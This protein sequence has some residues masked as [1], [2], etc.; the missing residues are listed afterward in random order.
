MSVPT[1]LTDGR[2][3]AER[4]ELITESQH[5]RGSG[6]ACRVAG[7]RVERDQ[8][9]VRRQGAGQFGELTRIAEA[10]RCRRRSAPTRTTADGSWP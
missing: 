6:S 2:V 3:H 1:V 9:H 8:V 7:R 4:A 10:G 5:V